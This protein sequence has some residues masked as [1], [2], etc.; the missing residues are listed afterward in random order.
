ME[1]IEFHRLI[2]AESVPGEGVAYTTRK[3][4]E[5]GFHLGQIIAHYVV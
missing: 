5:K 1:S 2:G 3:T 4:Y